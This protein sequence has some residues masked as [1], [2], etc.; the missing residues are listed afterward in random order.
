MKRIM[1]REAIA[2]AL[3]EEMRR[4]EKVFVMGEDVAIIGGVYKATRGLL[5]EFGP[6]RVRNTPLSELAIAGVATGAA[7]CG[8]RPVAEIMHIDFVGCGFDIMLN[9]MSKMCYKTN[10]R[11]HV[12]LV[13]RTQEGRGHSN[14]CTQSQS[15]EALFTHIPGL[16]VVLPS[17]P[18]DAKGLLKTAIR[19]NN[20]VI[21]I[22]HKGLYQTRGEVP[23]EEYLIPLGKADVKRY[24]KDVTFITYSKTVLTALEAAKELEAQG[25]DAEVLDLRSLVPLDFD[26]IAE[27]VRKTGRVI[28][29]HEACERGGYGAEI[30]AEIADRLFD[31]LDAPILRVCG[32]NIPVPNATLPEQESAPTVEKLVQAARNICQGGNHNG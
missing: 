23:E 1:Y 22:E 15:L 32:A 27:S 9:Q 18:Y 5:E 26:A 14:G 10:G 19:D 25:I 30:A 7:M 24:G 3:A 31:E 6:A 2:S 13:L 28:I 16:K 17:T 11:L 20:P 4:D 8:A 29:T 12:P 21:F